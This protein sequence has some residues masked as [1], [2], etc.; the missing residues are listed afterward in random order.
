[1]RRRRVKLPEA[2]REI[3]LDEPA[4]AEALVRLFGAVPH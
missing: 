1:M 2:M 3:G 4:L